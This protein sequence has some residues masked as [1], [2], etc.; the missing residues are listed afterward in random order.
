M[1]NIY[2][3]VERLPIS[4][5]DWVYESIPNDIYLEPQV[6]L[7]HE[8]PKQKMRKEESSKEDLK[9]DEHLSKEVMP[10]RSIKCQI[11]IAFS[12]IILIWIMIL[13]VILLK[14]KSIRA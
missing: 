1:S 3:N 12:I 14:P 13:L 10:T 5:D 6:S 2:V 7:I 11:L 9:P 4:I 8:L